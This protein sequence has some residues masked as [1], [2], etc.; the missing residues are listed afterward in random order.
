MGLLFRGGR[1]ITPSQDVIADIYCAGETITRIESDIDPS[2]L[3][4]PALDIIE[5]KGK[6]IIP[7]GIDPH[8]HIHLPFMGTNARDDHESASKAA[9]VG[10]TTTFIEMICPD[11]DDEPLDAF[12]TWAALAGG[13]AVCDYSF[14]MSVVRFRPGDAAQFQSIVEEHGIASFKVFLAYKGALDLGDEDLFAVMSLA[15]KLGVIVTAHCENAEAID[16]MQQQ[17]LGQGNTGPQWH[18]P[19]RPPCV[20]AEGVTHLCTFA[21]LTGAHVYIVHTSCQEAIEAAVEARTRGVNVWIEAVAPHLMLDKS[22]AEAPD[23]EGAKYVMSPP[24][25]AA[26]HKDAL[27]SALHSGVISTVGTDHAPFDFHG[28]KEMGRD[29][30]TRIP[31]GIPGI[32]ERIDLLHTYG[33]S[34]GRIDM[35]TLVDVCSTRAARLFGMYPR[36]GAIQVGS[37]AD[38]VV[39][40]PAYKGTFKA[41]ESMSQVDYNAYEGWERRGRAE[42]VSVRGTIQVRNAQ[43]TGRTGHGVLIKRKPT[44]F[45]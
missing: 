40:D 17:L 8:V 32:Q 31:N 11:P 14:H 9:L 19:S 20:E 35:S 44:H 39:Y 7:G 30:F 18:E 42:T 13:N 26:H 28:Q 43:Y 1:I 33:V 15:K 23:F 22:Y 6:Y 36:K 21:Q 16:A 12:N 41:S 3:D 4:D 25:R 27:W 37:D 38:I 34:T 10:G 24:L 5:A 29:D 45:G 2:S